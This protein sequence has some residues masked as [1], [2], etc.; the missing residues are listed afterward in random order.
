MQSRRSSSGPQGVA[1]VAPKRSAEQFRLPLLEG[2]PDA[3]RAKLQGAGALDTAVGNGLRELWEKSDLPAG[4]FAYEVV[5]FWH[6]PRLCLPELM[7]VVAI[8]EQFS[9][10]F[11]RESSVFPF[12]TGDGG[13]GLAVSDPADGAAIRAAEVVC[14][15]AAKIVVASF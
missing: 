9:A 6:L 7:N 2:M 14:G 5:S 8:V 12:R 11:L 13:L 15:E 10:R 3:A 4:K 1:A